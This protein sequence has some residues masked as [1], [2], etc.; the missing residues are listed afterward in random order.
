MA[1][2]K[3]IPAEL[4]APYVYTELEKNNGEIII[5]TAVSIDDYS[6]TKKKTINEQKEYQSS[7]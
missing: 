6:K 2:I 4:S 7:L 3:E 5:T 1:T